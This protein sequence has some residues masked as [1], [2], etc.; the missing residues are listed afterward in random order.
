LHDKPVRRIKQAIMSMVLRRQV[1][2]YTADVDSLADQYLTYKCQQICLL[3]AELNSTCQQ[4][5]FT[6]PNA[7]Q[8]APC[9][10][11]VLANLLTSK[12]VHL[13]MPERSFHPVV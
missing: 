4:E 12:R 6:P 9:A 2:D 5:F 8:P 3:E 11:Q 7:D 10:F 1:F 13:S